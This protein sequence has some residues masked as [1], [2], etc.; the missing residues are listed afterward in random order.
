MDTKK[1]NTNSI[2]EDQL[3][4]IIDNLNYVINK[5]N[6]TLNRMK[7]IGETLIDIYVNKKKSELRK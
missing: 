1:N 3:T 7:E 4:E 2:T 5:L 6:E